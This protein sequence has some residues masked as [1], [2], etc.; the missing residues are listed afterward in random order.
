MVI[1]IAAALLAQPMGSAVLTMNERAGT[2]LVYQT[3]LTVSAKITPEEE[4]ALPVDQRR[5]HQAVY[6][7]TTFVEHQTWDKGI[8]QSDVRT[9][10]EEPKAE[11]WLAVKENQPEGPRTGG[12]VMRRTAKNLAL[13]LPQTTDFAPELPV[14]VFINQPV[15]PGSAWRSQVVS[16]GR[17]VWATHRFI[18]WEERNGAFCA[19]IEVEGITFGG[20]PLAAPLVSWVDPAQGRVVRLEGLFSRAQGNT[21]VTINLVRAFVREEPA[22]RPN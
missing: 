14:P 7:S 10:T 6:T 19:R 15:K 3:T 5:R 20:I 12:G 9:W 13:T 1:G 4:R 11:G 2:R 16:E 22:K 18:A 17:Q 8:L 21:A